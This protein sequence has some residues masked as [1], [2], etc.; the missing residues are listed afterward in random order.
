MIINKLILQR[1]KR[2]TL[3]ILDNQG[4]NKS[5]K[6]EI[7]KKTSIDKKKIFLE[8]NKYISSDTIKNECNNNQL[9]KK[10]NCIES[11]NKN[12]SIYLTNNVDDILQKKRIKP[13]NKNNV[14]FNKKYNIENDDF[15]EFTVL[16]EYDKNDRLVVKSKFSSKEKISN[17]SGNTKIYNTRYSALTHK[18]NKPKYHISRSIIIDKVITV[19]EL[20][21]KLSVK[22]S[23]IINLM[24]KLGSVVNSNDI[25]NQEAIQ[26]IIE[27]MG[28]KVI[29]YDK[30][31]L[32]EN[33]INSNISTNKNPIFKLRAPIITIA[34]HVDHGKTSLLDFI[35]S[36]NLVD[37]EIGG[38]TQTIKA[39][40]INKNN[41]FITFI[42]TPGH[43]SF[44][45]MRVRG[46]KITD[47]IILVIA[48]D[49]GIMPQTIEVIEQAKLY[50][51]PMI[52]A[53]N[54]IDKPNSNIEKIKCDLAKY[55]IISEEWGGKNQFVYI[56]AKLGT[57]INELMKAI[58]IQTKL[59]N[60][61]TVFNGPAKGTIIESYLDKKRGPIVVVLIHEGS[62]KIGDLILCGLT[63]GRV[64][65]MYDDCKNYITT[66][67]PAIPVEIL[68]LSNIPNAGDLLIS[69][70]NEKH[71]KTIISYRKHE[72]DKL[73][74]NNKK[75]IN[76]NTIFNNSKEK[77]NKLNFLIKTDTYGISEVIINILNKL[78]SDKLQIK[79]ISSS[80]GAI[81]ETDILLA[82]SFRAIIIC[83]NVKISNI[84]HKISVNSNVC[85]KY[86]SIIYNLIDDI[87]QTINNMIYR[88]QIPVKKLLGIAEVRNI[89]IF[90]NYTIAGCMVIDGNIRQHAN[91]SIFRNN[92]I[93]FSGMIES[94][95]RFKN[96]IYEVRSGMDCGIVI[97]NYNNLL[98]GDTIKVFN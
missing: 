10:I 94:L 15:N 97:K 93:I 74:I 23:K 62:L 7:R 57:G 73:K 28:H 1:K 46:I 80:I 22:S 4:K 47:V 63:Y 82:K 89:F 71:V 9:S 27:D 41:K 53:I 17:Q 13:K 36:T 32:E 84:I 43:N 64:R 48:V 42:D 38:I 14:Y 11:N 75:D 83:F 30:D 96:N 16:N 50:Q 49:D 70:N 72:I 2:S 33:L 92:K 52:I 51:I 45:N 25:I 91:V 20:A 98:V 59:L 39:Y 29:F 24:A 67:L 21:N 18:F 3:N 87:K 66:A 55:N 37:Q 85:I 19:A 60:L 44:T 95:K 61:K 69:L 68:G 65:A 12:V 6:I 54:K 58:S 90:K 86:Y 26:L 79:I 34:G 5:I 76:I 77:I 40:Q 8:K 78:S 88:N 56:S 35:R 31:R 81:N